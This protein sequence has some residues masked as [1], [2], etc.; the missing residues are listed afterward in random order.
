MFRWVV[1]KYRLFKRV[2]MFSWAVVN[3]R[4]YK[5]VAMFSSGGWL[6]SRCCI[7]GL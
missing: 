3:Y 1:G 7:R 4:L 2:V 6:A 5:R